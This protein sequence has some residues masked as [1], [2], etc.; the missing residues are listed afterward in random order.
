MAVKRWNVDDVEDQ[1]IMVYN[2]RSDHI[3]VAAR[4]RITQ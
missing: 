2:Y 4:I 3:P 1:P